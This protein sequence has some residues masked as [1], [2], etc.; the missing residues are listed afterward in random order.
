MVLLIK[1]PNFRLQNK[2][3]KSKKVL[4]DGNL[5]GNWVSGGHKNVLESSTK[6][7][8]FSFDTYSNDGRLASQIKAKYL[9]SQGQYGWL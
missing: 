9:Y 7:Y 8:Y 2:S 1:S 3:K 4:T 6:Y 5:K